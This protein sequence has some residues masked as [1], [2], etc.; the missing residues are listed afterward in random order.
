MRTLRVI[1]TALLVGAWLS[2]CDSD[3]AGPPSP[4]S[5]SDQAIVQWEHPFPVEA[6]ADVWGMATDDVHAV[7]SYGQTLH[8]DGNEWR[9]VASPTRE[10]LIS[11]WGLPSGDIWA[12]GFV[13][14]IIHFDGREWRAQ[15]S[16]TQQYLFGVWASSPD[17]VLAVG[18]EGTVLR[19]DGVLWSTMAPP[20]TAD[21]L[22]IWG[23]S[24]NNVYVGAR[25]ALLHFDGTTWTDVGIQVRVRVIG[26]GGS[27]SNDVWVTDGTN[28]PWHFDGISWE[29]VFTRLNYPFTDFWGFA[30]DNA[31]GCGTDGF[32]SQFDGVTWS[33]QS[34]GDY[35]F[36]GLWGASDRDVW[37]SGTVINGV[38]GILFHYDGVE[39]TQKNRA[40][41][42]GGLQD[43]WSDPLGSVAYAVGLNGQVLT[44]S[45]GQWEVVPMAT[46]ADLSAVWGTPS[47]HVF[48]AADDGKCHRFD[49]A[50]W[51]E[52]DLGTGVRLSDVWGTS[53]LNVYAG[54]NRGVWHFD[55]SEWSLTGVHDRVSG[56]SGSGPA[57]V[58]V[59]G[60]DSLGENGTVRRFDGSTWTRIYSQPD[61]F[62]NSIESTGPGAVVI[63][64]STLSVASH[65]L[66][67]YNGSSWDDVSPSEIDNFHSIGWNAELGLLTSGSKVNGNSLTGHS[68]FRLH[69]GSWERVDTRYSALFGGMWG[70]L[71]GGAYLV[72]GSAIARCLLK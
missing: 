29:N 8:Y 60:L 51:E 24:T 71:E 44:R 57:E 17:T 55:G 52:F 46:S 22:C 5:S 65:R 47:G 54:S 12:V 15:D 59:A 56:I 10:H 58:Y 23:T 9:D 33:E 38:G 50:A 20:T 70:G 18:S 34:L 42:V 61:K 16:G 6:V 21:L 69:E 48:V 2:S 35:W 64:E 68:L 49:G 13:G 63:I 3:P 53:E 1:V 67:E 66:L 72:G 27:S 62:I 31:F 41:A 32:V 25:D 26:I 30:T 40:A 14:T 19:Y 11:L 43:I 28:W 7:G 45:D 39:W 4:P 37:V 36:E